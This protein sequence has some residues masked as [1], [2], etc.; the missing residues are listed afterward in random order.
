MY[1]LRTTHRITQFSHQHFLCTL[2]STLVS[3]ANNNTANFQAMCQYP[4]YIMSVRIQNF[5]PVHNESCC[6]SNF[7]YSTYLFTRIAHY[8]THVNIKQRHICGSNGALNLMKT[9]WVWVECAISH[10]IHRIATIIVLF[11][12]ISKHTYIACWSDA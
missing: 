12:R 8:I 5:V 11:C 10:T 7:V 3:N 2:H 6:C 4:Y 9:F 1:E